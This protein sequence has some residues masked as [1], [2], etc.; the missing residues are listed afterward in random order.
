VLFLVASL[1]LAPVLAPPAAAQDLLSQFEAKTT[2]FTLD[3]GLT[4]VVVEREDA[5]VVS[6]HTYVDVGSVDEPIGATGI[7]HMFEH[8][9]FKGTTTIGTKDI[10]KEMQALNR[11]EEIYR[12]LQRERARGRRADSARIDTLEKQFQE[13]QETAQSHIED[14]EYENLLERNGVE[15]LN[16]YTS[17][18]NTGYLY[19]LPANKLEL[20]FALEADRFKNPVLRE[21]YTE[22]DVV[23]EERR[24]RT[25]SNP[26]GRLLEEFL[27]TAFKAHPYGNPTIGHMSDLKSLTR[28]EAKDFY[29]TYYTASNMTI[30]IAG[31][32]NP[33]QVKR[34]AETYF[35]MLPAGTDPMP[36]NTEE[37]EQIAE[38]RVIIR[39]QTQPWFIAG[40]HRPSMYSEDAVVYDVLNRIL[41]DGRTSRLYTNLEETGMAL[42]SAAISAFPGEKYPPLFA[43]Y[44]IPSR[45]VSPDS[46][47]TAVYDVLDRIKQEGVTAEELERAK[48][49]IRADLI[50]NLDSNMGL[51]RRFSRYETLTGDW[52]D[53]F[54]Q[55]DEVEAVTAE[56]VQRVAQKTFQRENRTVAMIKTT[57]ENGQTADASSPD[58]SSDSSSK[59]A[60]RTSN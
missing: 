31:D 32:V 14:G 4:F 24:Q 22:R 52:R 7:A 37:P 8:M 41:S 56:D 57:E 58:G 50:G 44:A 11:Q 39:E 25:E 49:Q 1:A 13:A 19:S 36:I 43:V 12:R 6:F 21:F 59:Q 47:E 5:P 16:A 33:A 51:A 54:R 10:E 45:G 2:T 3:N 18:D 60:A 20:F 9:A 28:T 48:T 26:V 23:M 34:Y 17:P 29:D 27:T 55:L 46:V 30:G 15:G 42:N 38:R 40:Y 53:F 35:S